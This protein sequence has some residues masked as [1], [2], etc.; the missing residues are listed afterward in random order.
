MLLWYHSCR[1]KLQRRER[2]SA[3]WLG[4]KLVELHH[5]LQ[6]QRGSLNHATQPHPSGGPRPGAYALTAPDQF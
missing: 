6:K 4:L 1:K 5:P 2:R 3:K